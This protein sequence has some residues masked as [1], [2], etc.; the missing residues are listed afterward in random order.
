ME[1]VFLFALGHSGKLVCDGSKDFCVQVVM[2][3]EGWMST[4]DIADS[5]DVHGREFAAVFLHEDVVGFQ[6]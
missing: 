3:G 1:L 6:E 2:A 5:D 4:V